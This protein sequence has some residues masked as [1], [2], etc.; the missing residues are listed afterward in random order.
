MDFQGPDA[1]AT[2]TRNFEQLFFGFRQ[3]RGSSISHES[4]KE[5]QLHL[6]S[7]LEKHATAVASVKI[8]YGLV[9]KPFIPG[10]KKLPGSPSIV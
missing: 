4:K 1:I 5:K 7:Q 6:Y 9:V 2:T 3:I 10:V 8:V